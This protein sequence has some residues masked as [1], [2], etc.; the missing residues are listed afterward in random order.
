MLRKV[1]LVLV[2][3]GLVGGFWLFT[4]TRPLPVDVATIGRGPI[5]AVVEEEGKTRVRERYVVSA[6]VAGRLYRARHDE[7]DAVKKE[8]L[9]GEIDPLPLKS[10]VEEA[11]AKS[12]AL[13]RRIE[14]VSTRKPKPEEIERAKVA[15][16]RTQEQL[17]IGEKLLAEIQVEVQDAEKDLERAEALAR[18]RTIGFAELD[19]VKTLAARARQRLMAQE[20]R[21]K[22]RK[23]E[24]SMA[25]LDRGVL[26]ARLHDFDWQEQ[27]YKE[28]IAA[29][30]AA[31]AAMRDDLERT[32]IVS[33]ASGVV[34][35]I[36]RESEQVV[37]AGT[38]ILEIGDLADL[39][40]EAELL[41]E[42]VAHMREGMPAEVFG[43]A[44]GERVLG[45]RVTRIYPSAFTKISSLGVEQQRV[46]VIVGFDTGDSGLGD[47]FRVEV[48]V[49]L[50]ARPDVIRVPE[51]ALFRSKGRWHVFRVDGDRARLTPVETGIRDGRMREVLDGLQPGERVVLHPDDDLTD[52]AGVAPIGE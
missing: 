18:T 3:G 52:G 35:K 38:P 27:E 4:R 12:R 17:A 26:E 36:M 14:G 1:I 22:I 6:P 10:R 44:L 45:G 49:I 37:S 23:L 30:Q 31:L 21:V 24:I 19:E 51:G 43:R 41:S 20:V 48:R 34:L 29:V 33:P 39:E 8:E 46:R 5:R 13:E 15:E 40:V 25:K 11:E 50:E 47:L 28:Q 9:I 16:Q 2:I 32:R 7:G 42:D